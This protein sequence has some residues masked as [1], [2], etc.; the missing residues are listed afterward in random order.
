VP[1]ALS[2]LQLDWLEL[3]EDLG[4]DDIAEFREFINKRQLRNRK[5]ILELGRKRP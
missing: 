3:L 4:S 1:F 2:Q 5:L